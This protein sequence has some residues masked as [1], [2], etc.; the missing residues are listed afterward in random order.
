MSKKTTFNNPDSQEREYTRILMSFVNQLEADVN[1]ILMPEVGAISKQ[2]A[3]EIK[4]DT[5][6]DTIQMRMAELAQLASNGA[7]LVISKLPGQFIAVSKFNNGQ[8][9]AVFKANT[10]IAL[11]EVVPG[12]PVSAILGVNVFRNEPFLAPL[13]EGW[14]SDNA[15]LIKSIPTQFHTELEGILRR[16]VMNGVSV[17]DIKDQLKSR[18]SIT[19]NRA[20]L[21]AQDQTLKL[22]SSLTEYRLKSVGVTKFIWRTVG[23]SR[24]RPDHIERNG[25]EYTF[26]EGAGGELPG[27]PVRCRCR[28]E[29]VFED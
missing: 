13:A 24:V 6:S 3:S 25:K 10:G 15:A 2:F 26:K 22:N 14:V 21:I 17:G 16:G 5:W 19:E 28:A 20:K 8:F 4:T 7:I 12:A 11:P 9:K 29:G 18:F 1:K 23:D 27:Q